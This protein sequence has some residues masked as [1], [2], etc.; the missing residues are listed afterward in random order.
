MK[1]VLLPISRGSTGSSTPGTWDSGEYF[2]SSVVNQPS[3]HPLHKSWLSC[4]WTSAHGTSACAA[5]CSEW[6]KSALGTCWDQGFQNPPHRHDGWRQI[7]EQMGLERAMAGFCDLPRKHWRVKMP[8]ERKFCQWFE[9]SLKWLL[10]SAGLE[11]FLPSLENS[12]CFEASY[13]LPATAEPN[14]IFHPPKNEQWGRDRKP[15]DHV[16][17]KESPPSLQEKK[18]LWWIV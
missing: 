8:S 5:F 14:T 13:V 12:Q 9:P 4:I 10:N 2:K 17:L 6:S 3:W 15:A 7:R 18:W 1:H 16:E 11:G